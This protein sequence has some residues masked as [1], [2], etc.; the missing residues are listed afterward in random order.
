[1]WNSELQYCVCAMEQIFIYKDITKI[2]NHY[3][4]EV[5]FLFLCKAPAIG[6]D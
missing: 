4:A 1:M 2:A 6:L 3:R 5:T